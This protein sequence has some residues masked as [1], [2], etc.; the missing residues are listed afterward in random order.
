MAVFNH[1]AALEGQ[2]IIMTHE[3]QHRQHL[4]RHNWGVIINIR[5]TLQLYLYWCVFTAF[6]YM[7][8]HLTGKMYLVHSE[9]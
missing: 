9:L 5:S 4:R 3:K 8:L 7:Y 2:L 6:I 1:T